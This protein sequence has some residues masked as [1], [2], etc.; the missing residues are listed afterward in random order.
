MAENN[1]AVAVE[2]L[3]QA[4]RNIEDAGHRIQAHRGATGV[5]DTF[6]IILSDLG[7]IDDRLR[8][9]VEDLQFRATIHD[10]HHE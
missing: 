2:L 9:L 3:K 5:A 8:P 1:L 7:S 6:F 4:R 10:T